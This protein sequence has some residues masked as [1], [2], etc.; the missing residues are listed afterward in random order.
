[1]RSPRPARIGCERLIAQSR[2]RS[3]ASRQRKLQGVPI[4]RLKTFEKW[5]EWSTI[6]PMPSWTRW[7]TRSTMASSTR[8]V[9]LV[10]PPE[11]H[12][13]V[14][15]AASCGRPFSGWSSVAVPASMPS[16]RERRG[17]GGVDAVGV[18]L[19]DHRV[20]ALVD[21]LVPDDGSDHGSPRRAGLRCRLGGRVPGRPGWCKGASTSGCRADQAAAHCDAAP[22]SVLVCGSVAGRTGRPA[23]AGSEQGEVGRPV[24]GRASLS[25]IR[26]VATD[27]MARGRELVVVERGA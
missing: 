18:D 22:R 21:E 4:S 15:R 20:L 2:S 13:D 3:P 9:R 26:A 14:R 8:A 16:P 12:V 24:P 1:M 5:P 11:Q 7:A 6:R 27:V 19:P 23:G 10:A 25:T 17:D